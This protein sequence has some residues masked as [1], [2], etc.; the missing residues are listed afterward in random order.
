MLYMRIDQIMIGNMIGDSAVGIY[1]VAVKMVEVWYF[2]PVAIV[3][4]LFPKIIKLR[5]VN[6]LEYNKRLQFLYD[7]LVVL[8]VSIAL[9]VTF[10]S[11]YIIGFFYT[12]QYTEASILIKIYA[13]VSVFYF[14]SSASGRWYIN[15]GLQKYALNRNVIGLVMGVVFKFLINPEI[16]FIRFCLCNV[17]CLC[18]CWIFI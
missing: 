5:E 18:M 17:D 10:L 8:S 13:W 6:V 16:W 7:I 12:H 3:S 4:S 1:S 2:F 15:E 14:L 11:D 9:I